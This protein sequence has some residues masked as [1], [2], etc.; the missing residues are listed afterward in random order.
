MEFAFTA[1][2]VLGFI[3]GFKHAFEPDH[4]SAISTLLHREP[5]LSSV[6]RIGLAWGAGHTTMLMIAVLIVGVL[7]LQI[8]PRYMSYLEGIV[9]FMLLVLGVWAIYV[10]ISA[11]LAERRSPDKV[12]RHYDHEQGNGPVR[13]GW[14]SYAVGL[15]HGLAGSGALLLLVAASL[16]TLGERVFYTAVFGVGSILGM[17][18]VTIAIAIP[19]LASRSRPVLFHSLTGLSGALSI[20]VGYGLFQSLLM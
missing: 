1:A 11:I 12:T 7:R 15:I 20:V 14:T 4:I 6:L 2:I 17:G 5:K 3:T 18:M 10:A 13:N 9:A 8:S 19:F 16:T